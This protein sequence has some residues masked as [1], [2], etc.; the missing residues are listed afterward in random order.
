MTLVFRF[1][2]Q[3]Q[4]IDELVTVHK[5]RPRCE[6]FMHVCFEPRLVVLQKD[7]LKVLGDNPICVKVGFHLKIGYFL[8]I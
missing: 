6:Y 1:E 8:A 5:N 7:I 2:D 4:L 3:A